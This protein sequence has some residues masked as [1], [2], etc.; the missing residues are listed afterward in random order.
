MSRPP[1]RSGRGLRLTD[2]PVA[3]EADRLGIELVQPEK[4]AEPSILDLLEDLSP[5]VMVCAAYGAYMPEE[6]LRKAPLGVVNIHPSL[7]PA[8]RGAAPVARAILEG[9]TRTGVTFMLTDTE[10]WDTGPVLTSFPTVVEPDD[11]TGSLSR[12]LSELAGR[13][14]VDV[15]LAYA[16]GE[17]SPL[18]QQGETFYARKI[19]KSETWIDWAQGA[20]RIERLVRALQ[21]S[22][23]ARTRYGKRLIKLIRSEVVSGD[24]GE[25]GALRSDDGG[26]V[27][28][29]GLDGLRPLVVQ[30]ESKRAMPMADFVRG[31]GPKDGER[32][33]GRP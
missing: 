29:C 15:I 4:P 21:P 19:D 33:G 31:Y 1:R 2:P 18:P 27:V 12:K 7:L 10:G 26:M 14:V 24:F 16:G 28:A 3:R 30:P 25:P 5:R 32:F 6:L 8:Y 13:K 17:L 11:T 22:P 23:G 20:D 9:E